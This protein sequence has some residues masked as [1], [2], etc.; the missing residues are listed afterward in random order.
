MSSTGQ[1][2]SIKYLYKLRAQI[3]LFALVQVVSLASL[4]EL[5][6]VFAGRMG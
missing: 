6:L 3:L 1:L 2:G 4:D 5:A